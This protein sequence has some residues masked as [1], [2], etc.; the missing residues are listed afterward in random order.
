MPTMRQDAYGLPVSTDAV[1]TV[2]A[3][4]Q[5]V[6][7]LLSWDARALE[8]FRAASALDPGLALAHARRLWARTGR[9]RTKQRC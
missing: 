9:E 2:E 4:D 1:A 7:G 5:A 8:R 3:Y 6:E